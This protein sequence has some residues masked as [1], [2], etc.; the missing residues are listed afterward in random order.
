M[1]PSDKQKTSEDTIY[2]VL[3]FWILS[4]KLKS[5]MRYKFFLLFVTETE[6][7]VKHF[8][9]GGGVQVILLVLKKI[10]I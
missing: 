5:Q 4:R 6:N 1:R 2:A 10:Y 7:E 3:V 9:G 8:V